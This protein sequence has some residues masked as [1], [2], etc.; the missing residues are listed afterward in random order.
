MAGSPGSRRAGGAPA[1]A[2]WAEGG[3]AA[4]PR[5]GGWGARRPGNRV[6][7][8]PDCAQVVPNSGAFLIIPAHSSARRRREPLVPH[9]TVT[10][11]YSNLG[12]RTEN[13]GV[14]GSIPSLPTTTFRRLANALSALS[15]NCHRN[16]HRVRSPRPSRAPP[17]A[18][19]PHRG[20]RSRRRSHAT[21]SSRGSAASSHLRARADSAR[22]PSRLTAVVCLA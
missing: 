13:P 16:S 14:G 18:S 11:T 2:R 9:Q 20:D 22:S 17:R 1:S 4:A 7:P 15:P 19:Y 5:G 10:R 3:G 8:R 12:N 6:G 21:T